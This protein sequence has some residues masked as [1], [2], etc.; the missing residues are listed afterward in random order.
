MKLI[1]YIALSVFITGW[2]EGSEFE[3]ATTQ[4]YSVTNSSNYQQLFAAFQQATADYTNDTTDATALVALE[5]IYGWVPLNE[6]VKFNYDGIKQESENSLYLAGI[7]G[8]N[9]ALNGGATVDSTTKQALANNIWQRL[10]GLQPTDED[11]TELGKTAVSTLLLLND[12][13]GLEAILTDTEYI[14]NLQST[15]GWDKDSSQ[16]KF[17]DLVTHYTALI[18]QEAGARELAA[19]YELMRLRKVAGATEI[20]STN[21]VIDLSKF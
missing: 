4:K 15:D 10:S 20:V 9:E 19:F 6:R 17:A 21:S 14:K 11:N 8:C 2:L 5:V 12:D 18:G 13:R 3:Q 7:I 1:I 16:T